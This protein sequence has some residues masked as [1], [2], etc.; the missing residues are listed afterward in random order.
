MRLTSKNY[1]QGFQGLSQSLK[2]EILFPHHV[3]PTKTQSWTTPPLHFGA[4]PVACVSAAVASESW[5]SE[6]TNDPA[7]RRICPW[8]QKGF[9][10]SRPGLWNLLKVSH[11]F[12]SF[13]LFF[14]HRNMIYP[15]SKSEPQDFFA[16]TRVNLKPNRS[17]AHWRW[18]M[19]MPSSQC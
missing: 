19:D 9:P 4:F 6:Q 18:V 17:G 2:K 8:G 13:Q 11:A 16:E 10:S 14:W 7:R 1:I 15:H 5:R 12:W 3:T